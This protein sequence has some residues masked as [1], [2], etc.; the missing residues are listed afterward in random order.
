MKVKIY[1]LVILLSFFLNA[2]N[3][4]GDESSLKK[5]D[6]KKRIINYEDTL[7]Q[8]Q[9]DPEKF[10]KTSSIF[11][12]ELINRLT[13]YYRAFP[14]DEYSSDCLFKIHMKYSELNLHDKSV[15]YGDTLL[16]LF[17]KYKNKEFLLE[18]MASAY[19]VYIMPRDTSKVRYYYNILLNEK[20]VRENKK[21]DIRNRL[22]NLDLTFDDYILKFNNFPQ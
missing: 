22:A 17:P 2:C 4:T 1:Q 10:G 12:M 19:D 9:K 14:K 11:S 16:S 15:V 6:L 8:I 3:Q 20:N 13:A 21:R 18:S 5:E 7:S